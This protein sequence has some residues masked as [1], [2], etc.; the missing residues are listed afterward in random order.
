MTLAPPHSSIGVG[1]KSPATRPTSCCPT[2]AC[3]RRPTSPLWGPRI[4]TVGMTGDPGNPDN[5]IHVSQLSTNC[6]RMAS[7]RS[8]K[9]YA[10]AGLREALTMSRHRIRERP[11]YPLIVP[12]WLARKSSAA[13]L[14]SWPSAHG[15]CLRNRPDR[16]DRDFVWREAQPQSPLDQLDRL[17]E[18]IAPFLGFYIA[19]RVFGEL[20]LELVLDPLQELSDCGVHP[21]VR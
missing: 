2:N 7:N 4:V 21:R 15:R 1:R 20:S 16:R 8:S 14:F 10:G 18:V 6:W 17:S 19:A 5:A 13:M 12:I 11:R 9:P 3:P